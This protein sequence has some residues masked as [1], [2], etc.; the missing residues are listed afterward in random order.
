M[1]ADY[2]VQKVTPAQALH[3]FYQARVRGWFSDGDASLSYVDFLEVRLCACCRAL[4]LLF[5]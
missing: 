3:C 5:C 4:A 2:C 1:L